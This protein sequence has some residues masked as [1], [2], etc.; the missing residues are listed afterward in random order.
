[1]KLKM[2]G[3]VLVLALSG[4]ASFTSDEVPET[5]VPLVTTTATV[6]PNAYVDFMFM[7]GSPVGGTAVEMPQARD[8]LKPQLETVLR[9]SQLFDRY[10]LNAFERQPEDYT[11][12]LR[13]YNDGS[14]GL[15]II[16]GF[17]SGFTFM[18]IPATAKDQYTMTLEVLNAD[19]KAVSDHRN[20]DSIRTWMGWIFLPFVGNT[21]EEAVKDSFR[22]QLNALLKQ[23]VDQNAIR[24]AARTQ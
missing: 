6:K 1:M 14:D 20:H 22:R 7:R 17:I 2:I 8:L 11:L 19:G 3:C 21:T 23:S 15:G 16:S 10:T 13:V 5:Q 9:E 24:V 18:V 12:K 4:C